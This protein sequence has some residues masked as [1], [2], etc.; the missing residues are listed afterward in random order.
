MYF[1]SVSDIFIGQPI[2]LHAAARVEEPMEIGINV[3]EG[4]NV[5]FQCAMITAT[6]TLNVR[7]PGEPFGT[8]LPTN[9]REDDELTFTLVNVSQS[10]NGTEF[11]CR[12]GGAE[13]DI[14]VIS[15]QSK[16]CST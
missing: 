9:L 12:G 5:T 6:P 11:Q 15:V 16:L 3:T 10:N 7:F 14:G 8:T 13:T 2:P 1:S 4:G